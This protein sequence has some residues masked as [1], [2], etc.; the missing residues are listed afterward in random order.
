MTHAFMSTGVPSSLFGDDE[1]KE[2]WLAECAAARRTQSVRY[3]VSPRMQIA[4]QRGFLKAGQTVTLEDLSGGGE[5]AW[6]TLE[7]LLCSGLV[8]EADGFDDPPQAA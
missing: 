7:R 3:A 1:T 5:P 6:Q 2:R 4:T 8:I